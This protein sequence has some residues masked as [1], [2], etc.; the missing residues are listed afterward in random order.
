[1]RDK[2]VAL[3]T[4]ATGQDGSYLCELLL[5][6][7]YEVHV[8][9]RP[10]AS[11]VQEHRTWRI[12]HIINKLHVHSGTLESYASVFDIVYSVKPDECYHLAAQSFVHLS[13][14]DCH[15]TMN[16]NINGT[17][18]VLSALHK[19]VPE[20]KFYFAG[21]SEMFGL[22]AE[23][24][25]TENTKFHPRSPYGISKSTGFEITR[26]YRE[27]YNMF[28]CSGILFN[29][30][31]ERRGHQF[32]TRKITRGVARILLG[33]QRELRL[34]NLDA[35]RDWGHAKDYVKAMHL[36]LQQDKPDDYV[37]AT[38]E[39][40]SVRE[41]VESAF[42]IAGL[43]WEKY[44]V[45]DEKFYRPAEIHTLMGD[46]SKAYNILGWE[47]KVTFKELVEGMVLNDIMLEEH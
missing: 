24:P 4:G 7:G 26:N 28:A 23:S 17:L 15:S 13:F 29:H 34:G 2:R 27:A 36:M 37:V 35:E 6:N 38:G 33:K 44:V 10:V 32:V 41:F 39:N 9:I 18:H 42:T 46:Y 12:N 43:D 22:V 8:M 14:D 16:A 25:Q 3:V 40:H 20:C 31:S 5:E 1:M 21:S 47:P 30:E 45:V 19:I 11:E